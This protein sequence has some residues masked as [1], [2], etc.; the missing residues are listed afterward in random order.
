MWYSEIM[1][2]NKNYNIKKLMEIII[3]FIFV[4]VN[5]KPYNLITPTIQINK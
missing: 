3:I 5:Q 4:N 2:I 1:V